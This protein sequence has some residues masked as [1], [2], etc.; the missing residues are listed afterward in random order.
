MSIKLRTRIVTTRED[1]SVARIEL[2]DDFQREHKR[3]PGTALFAVAAGDREP[4]ESADPFL[5]ILDRE[6]FDPMW[7]AAADPGV[8]LSMAKYEG[9]SRSDRSDRGVLL[10]SRDIDRRVNVAMAFETSP[11]KG[12]LIVD[13][14]LQHLS[15]HHRDLWRRGQT[16]VDQGGATLCESAALTSVRIYVRNVATWLALLES[17]ELESLAVKRSV[18]GLWRWSLQHGAGGVRPS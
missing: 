7:L 15:D 13:C 10:T 5:S 17:D 3:G 16:D 14:D 4:L 6:E 1:W 8:D 11:A 9:S 12:R 2:L 18:T